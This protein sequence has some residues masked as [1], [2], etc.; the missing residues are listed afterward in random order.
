MRFVAWG[1]LNQGAWAST[2]K[3]GLGGQAHSKVNLGRFYCCGL[4]KYELCGLVCRF[5]WFA[6]QEGAQGGCVRVTRRDNRFSPCQGTARG[7]FFTSRSRLG[8]PLALGGWWGMCGL[9]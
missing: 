7:S 5:H 4:M 8:L 9:F 2:F 3:T 6:A 1:I